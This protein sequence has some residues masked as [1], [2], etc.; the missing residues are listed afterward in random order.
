MDF[1][2]FLSA[3]ILNIIQEKI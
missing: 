3:I 1:D 2:E